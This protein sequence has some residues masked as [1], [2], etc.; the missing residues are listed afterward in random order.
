MGR[1]AIAARTLRFPDG[2]FPVP[3]ALFDAD[4]TTAHTEASVGRHGQ[5]ILGDRDV[6]T[7]VRNRNLAAPAVV[8]GL[9][10]GHEREDGR[11]AGDVFEAEA[12]EGMI[13]VGGI[14]RKGVEEGQDGRFGPWRRGG[15]DGVAPHMRGSRR[16]GVVRR[17]MRTCCCSGSTCRRRIVFRASFRFGSR[18][19]R[20]CFA[21]RL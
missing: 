2:G 19:R 18:R 12:V 1:V 16:G 5:T 11:L 21:G 17:S 3:A 6:G 14:A 4:V 10:V 8:F 9:L 7:L 13:A 15:G 20:E